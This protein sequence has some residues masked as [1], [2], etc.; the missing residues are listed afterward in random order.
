MTGHQINAAITKIVRSTRGQGRKAISPGTVNAFL[1][2][3]HSG[4]LLE[5]FFFISHASC[6]SLHQWQGGQMTRSRQSRASDTSLQNQECGERVMFVV[7]FG[8]VGYHGTSTMCE[9][10]RRH[11]KGRERMIP[12]WVCPFLGRCC[13]YAQRISATVPLPSQMWLSLP[14]RVKRKELRHC[15]LVAA[16][17]RTPTKL[18]FENR[19]SRNKVE[20]SS[21]M[22]VCGACGG[23]G[24]GI[25]LHR[26]SAGQS[27]A[28]FS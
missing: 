21:P 1:G 25:S 23:C 15:I 19:A 22:R 18:L 26:L 11:R 24:E 2:R 9:P 5:Q 28:D 16:S 27:T 7:G 13:R 8:Q 17:P 10:H 20:R 3:H 4:Q 12:K 6:Q 14:L